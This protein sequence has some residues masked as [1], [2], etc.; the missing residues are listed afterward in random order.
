ML[1]SPPSTTSTKVTTKGSPVVGYSHPGF[2]VWGGLRSEFS[3]RELS[4]GV[5]ITGIRPGPVT[6]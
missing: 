4:N 3:R 1:L 5:D 2:T 6:L